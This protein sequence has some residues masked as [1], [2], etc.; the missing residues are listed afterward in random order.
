MN[1]KKSGVL[2]KKSFD[3]DKYLQHDLIDGKPL[4]SVE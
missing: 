4:L 1:K 2:D 3:L